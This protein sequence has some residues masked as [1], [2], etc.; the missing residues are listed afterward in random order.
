[1]TNQTEMRKG[2]VECIAALAKLIDAANAP[3]VDG[4]DAREYVNKQIN[5]SAE[6]LKIFGPLTPRQEG[7]ILCLAEYIH[8]EET[9]GI[10]S[11]E[12][13]TPFSTDTKEEIDT[14]VAEVDAMY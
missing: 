9:T 12:S 1:M 6:L 14:F 5:N 8:E 2:S 3:Q 11:L 10:P 13:W 7:M 4:S